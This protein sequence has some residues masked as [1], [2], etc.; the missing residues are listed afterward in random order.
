MTKKVLLLFP[1]TGFDPIKPRMPS[2]LIY[3]GTFLKEKGYEPII[4][5]TRV[6]KDY[7][8]KI[9]SHINDSI[10]VG[11]TTMTGMQILFA[12]NLARFVRKAAPKIP[13]IWGG[14]HPSLLPEQTI[15]NKY[16]DVIVRGEGEETFYHLIKAIDDKTALEKVKGITFKD[17]E[18]NVI[19]TPNREFIDLN[20][21]PF[22]NWELIDYKKYRIFDILSARGCPH[23]CGFCYN[24]QFNCQNWRP[25]SAKRVLKEIEYVVRKYNVKQLNFIDDNFFTDKKRVEE[26]CRGII[27]KG[28]KIKWR[29]SCRVDY[30]NRYGSK[31][32]NLLNKAGLV[33][34]FIGAESGSQR[35][36]NLIKKDITIKQTINTVKKCKDNNIQ[37]QYSYMIGF[38][39]ETEK[40]LMKTFKQIDLIKR[41]DPHAMIN[42]IAIYTPYPG[43]EMYEQCKNLGFKPPRTLEEWG[44]YTYTFAN[45]PYLGSKRIVYESIS[46]ISRFIFYKKELKEKFITPLTRIPFEILSVMA[47]LRWE[48]KFFSFPIEWAV[49]KCY[50]V[51]RRKRQLKEIYK[52]L[53]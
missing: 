16:V 12:L 39:G 38:P 19:N 37:A 28:F 1:R 43:T 5:D 44:E 20:K 15:Q 13:I 8:R 14:V 26:I 18:G 25:K 49:L 45:L 17:K 3:I 35:M 9:I 10:A 48:F 42:M 52:K 23:R 2:P 53:K 47:K 21:L 29:A 30:I 36:L 46:Y 27:K 33:E 34:L 40:D 6:D 50:L 41:I 11:I 31:F 51:Y 32:L 24:I 22:P 7:K 4:V